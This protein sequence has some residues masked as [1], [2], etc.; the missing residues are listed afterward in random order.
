MT[1]ATSAAFTWHSHVGCGT[2]ALLHEAACLL[3]QGVLD[4][5][6]VWFEGSAQLWGRLAEHV[7]SASVCHC[8]EGAC[9]GWGGGRGKVMLWGPL[10]YPWGPCLRGIL[11]GGHAL[12]GGGGHPA[13]GGDACFGGHGISLGPVLEGHAWGRACW[14][15]RE[16]GGACL[17]GTVINLEACTCNQHAR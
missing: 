3:R 6:E 13:R 16:R 2:V 15:H 11:G 14:G 1:A 12:G 5:D 8:V 9:W 17:G 10:G 7:A 4:E